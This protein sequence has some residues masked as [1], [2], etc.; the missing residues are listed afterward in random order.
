MP[1]PN[2]LSKGEK[3]T[4]FYLDKGIKPKGQEKCPFGTAVLH[5]FNPYNP[6]FTKPRTY[7]NV[8]NFKG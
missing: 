7:Y 1:Y 3:C 4:R 5:H 8:F 2:S 6:A